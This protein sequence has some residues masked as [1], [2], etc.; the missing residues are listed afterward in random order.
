MLFAIWKLVASGLLPS[1]PPCHDNPGLR[2]FALSFG[3]GACLMFG[4]AWPR[5]HSDAV[6]PRALGAALGVASGLLGGAL[7]DLWC[8]LAYP[9]HVLFGHV[10]PMWLLGSLGALLGARWLGIEGSH[11]RHGEA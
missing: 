9:G 10:L 11:A 3:L 6:H 7:V 4:L 5:R 1:P 8:P 2:C